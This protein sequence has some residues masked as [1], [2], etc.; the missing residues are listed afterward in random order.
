MSESLGNFPLDHSF[1]YGCA[2]VI[3]H[4]LIVIC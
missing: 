1:D 4:W 3:E 2:A